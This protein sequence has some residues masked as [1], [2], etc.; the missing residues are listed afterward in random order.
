MRL[1]DRFAQQAPHSISADRIPQ[2]LAG[3][4][5]VAVVRQVIGRN[6]Q[7]HEGMA[8]DSPGCAE[9][10][11]ILFTAQSQGALHGSGRMAAS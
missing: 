5:T 7:D 1:P 9:T 11:E 10:R 6:A 8:P 2:P 3:D 4:E